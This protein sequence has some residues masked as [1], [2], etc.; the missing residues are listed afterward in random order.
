MFPG[1][2]TPQVPKWLRP[3]TADFRLSSKSNPAINS[4]ATSEAYPFRFMPLHFIWARLIW[5]DILAQKQGGDEGLSNSRSW[6][7]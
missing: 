3:S 7:D 6:S 1:P 4:A 5:N 2:I